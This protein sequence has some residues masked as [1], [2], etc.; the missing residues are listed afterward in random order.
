MVY[1][2]PVI[3]GYYPDPSIC[4]SNDSYYLVCSSFQCFP[5]VPLFESKD[6]VNW[7]Q[8]GNVLT[9]ESQLPLF[10]ARSSGG[11]YAPTIRENNGRFYMVTTNVTGGGNF[12]VYTDDIYGEWSEPIFVDQSGI[13]PSLYFEDNR[14]YFV[15]NGNDP[16]KDCIP[17]IQL[18]EIDIKTGKKLTESKYIWHGSGGRYVEAPHIYHIGGHYILMC[19]EGGT[20][21]G[22]MVT[23]AESDDIWGEYKGYEHNPVLTNRNLGGYSLQAVGHGD[24]IEDYSGNYWMVH[25]GFRVNEE[26][27]NYH[28]LGRE[29]F[30]T[31]VTFD[32]K[33]FFTAGENGTATL[34]VTTDRL[35]ESLFQKPVTADKNYICLRNPHKENYIITDEKI[36]LIGTD[37]TLDDVDSP[38][39]LGLRQLEFNAV[40]T[41]NVKL[42][43]DG[44]SGITLYMDENHHY[45]LELEKTDKGICGCVLINI[46]DVKD[47]YKKCVEIS[48]DNAKLKIIAKPSEYLFYI[49]GEEIGTA[50]ARYLSSEVAGG[51]TGVIIGLF[52][53]KTEAE[54]T[55][56]DITYETNN[57]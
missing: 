21:Y 5:G 52:A 29:T 47:Y 13:D 45:D 50:Q 48:S 22:H 14:A 16:D 33:G 4:K 6:L 9:R 40:I 42:N 56:F 43:S 51:F 35:P 24:L 34:E 12:Y 11:I 31:P 49:N 32:G 18:C 46:G 28:H 10:K 27:Q 20:E 30:L 1:K 37:I 26:Y 19:A 44:A 17:G 3:S 55:E 25:L 54:F 53:E 39:F 36:T 2:N 8:I 41:S 23:V 7:K 38:T 15:S 57:S